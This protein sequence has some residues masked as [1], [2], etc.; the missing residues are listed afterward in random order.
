MVCSFFKCSPNFSA[1]ALQSE[2]RKV[3]K[4]NFV[5]FEFQSMSLK[6]EQAFGKKKKKLSSKQGQ[7]GHLLGNYKDHK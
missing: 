5:N 2:I 4:S 1:H 7:K 6:I 3:T